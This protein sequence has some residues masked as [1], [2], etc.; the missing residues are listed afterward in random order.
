LAIVVYMLHLLLHW[1]CFKVGC[2]SD[3]GVPNHLPDVLL[4]VSLL[5]RIRKSVIQVSPAG[6]FVRVNHQTAVSLWLVEVLEIPFF[7]FFG[8]Y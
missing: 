4:L 7:R 5:P 6:M 3:L 2:G 8:L 1:R